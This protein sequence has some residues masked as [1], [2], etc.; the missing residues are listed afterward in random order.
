MNKRG[1]KPL[2]CNC[3]FLTVWVGNLELQK[4]D[5]EILRF[6]N[7]FGY[8]NSDHIIKM[9]K[10]SN[11]QRASQILTRLMKDDLIAKHK[12]LANES[13]LYTLKCKAV[14]LINGTR[15]K[16]ISLQNLKHNLL[17]IDVYIDLMLENSNFK[18]LS[19]RDLRIGKKFG[20][21]EKSSLPDLLIETAE[22]NGK[23]DIA[24]EVELTK[25]NYKRIKAVIIQRQRKYI[26]THYYCNRS[27]YE[28]IKKETQLKSGFKVYNYFDLE[29]KPKILEVVNNIE[30]TAQSELKALQ[31]KVIKLEN[32]EKNT[33][34]RLE[35][36]QKNIDAFKS[37]FDDLDFKKAT[38]GG[39]HSLNNDDLIKLRNIVRSL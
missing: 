14:N 11:R 12:V 5:I 34:Q 24:I 35:V 33:K 36:L 16:K 30:E 23:K 17:V 37:F 2:D 25:K 4:R 7:K 27:V 8:V 26:E 28:F 10:F 20:A 15:F 38:F 39:T 9:F 32:E 29:E 1:K 22:Q 18:I 31:N 6:I 19:D 21:K 3:Y 13:N